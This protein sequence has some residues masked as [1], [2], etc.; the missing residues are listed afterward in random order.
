MLISPIA[1]VSEH[2]ETLVELDRDY[3]RLAAEVGCTPYLRA[4]TP[5]VEPGFIDGLARLVLEALERPSGA[6]PGG[7]WRCPAGHAKCALRE[8]E[9]QR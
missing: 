1:F 3:A 6:A 2:V 5:G 9:A 7:P 8:T 4:A